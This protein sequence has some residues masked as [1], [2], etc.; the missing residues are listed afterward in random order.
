MKFK[1]YSAED[2]RNRVILVANQQRQFK[3]ASELLNEAV[4]LAK[5]KK[6]KS[7][8]R[9]CLTLLINVLH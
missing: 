7:Q 4:I 1:S 5:L 6:N 8:V 3:S 9:I 2:C